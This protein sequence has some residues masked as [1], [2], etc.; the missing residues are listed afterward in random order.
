M[1]S[2]QLATVLFKRALGDLARSS[3]I[4]AAILL[5][6]FSLPLQAQNLG[7]GGATLNNA[8]VQELRDEVKQLR[9]EVERLRSAVSAGSAQAAT[10]EAPAPPAVSAQAQPRGTPQY[11]GQPNIPD[12]AMA[13]KANGGDLS[14]L[15]NLLRTDRLTLGGYGDFQF[16]QPSLNERNDGGGTSTFQSTRFILG[17]AAVLSH[18]QNIVFNSPRSHRSLLVPSRHEADGLGRWGG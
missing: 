12:L 2:Y 5:A 13:T 17:L 11:T 14:G 15:G 8:D 10:S 6:G 18:K 4:F 3:V 9:V 7:A 1:S 16:R